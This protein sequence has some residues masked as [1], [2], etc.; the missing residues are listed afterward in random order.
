VPPRGGTS[1]SSTVAR[2]GSETV[3]VDGPWVHEPRVGARFAACNCERRVPG[4]VHGRGIEPRVHGYARN[5]T[6]GRC[7][8]KLWRATT[9]GEHR[10][11]GLRLPRRGSNGTDP[12]GEQCFE[13]GVPFVVRRARRSRGVDGTCGAPP[14]VSRRP[15][16]ATARNRRPGSRAGASGKA[17]VKDLWAPRRTKD[18]E[19][20][21]TEAT[22]RESGHGSPGRESSGGAAPGTR[23]VRNGGEA[24]D[25]AGGD[26]GRYSSHQTGGRRMSDPGHEPHERRA[27]PG[28]PVGRRR[29]SR[30][31]ERTRTPR[32]K[33]AWLN[34]ARRRSDEEDPEVVKTTRGERRSR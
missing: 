30:T 31:L 13:A 17:I 20:T 9:P 3:C 24:S 21:R 23:T 4:D 15:D 16:S 6:R 5:R 2:T 32:G 18:G 19:R 29:S 11:R 22:T 33:I 8:R 28:Q 27:R 34:T 7:R 1:D 25:A 10:P 12:R 14:G 26:L